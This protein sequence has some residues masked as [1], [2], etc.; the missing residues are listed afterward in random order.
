MLL[1]IKPPHDFRRSPRPI[2]TT[3]KYWKASEYRAFL[4]FYAIP[5]LSGFLPPDYIHHLSLLVSSI[6]ILLGTKIAP[7]DLEAAR[8]MLKSFYQLVPKLYP[9]ELCT[10]NVHSLIHLCDCVQ[11]WG[12]LWCYSAFGFENLHGYMRKHCHGTRNVL[13]QLIHAV[14]TR[15]ALPT[16]CQPFKMELKTQKVSEH[17]LFCINLVRQGQRNMLLDVLHTK[18]YVMKI[19]EHWRLR[20]SQ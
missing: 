8:H 7:S 4:L 16:I 12:P 9:Q 10:T 6:H 5:L 13:P 18:N 20:T 2:E 1:R 14:Q 15:Q 19:F 17:C 11:R 3:V